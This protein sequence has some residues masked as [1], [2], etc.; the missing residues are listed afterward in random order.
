MNFSQT[1]FISVNGLFDFDLTF[2]TEA[3]LF[4][5]LAIVV[6]FA[7]L[8]PISKQ[9]DERAEFLNYTIKKSAILLTFGFEKLQNCVGLLTSEIDELN[10]EIKLVK[11]YTNTKFE[12]EAIKVQKETSKIVSQLKGD[13]SIKSAY[14]IAS[15]GSDLDST[16]TKFFDK[17]F[18]SI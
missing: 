15:L 7:F 17:K 9:L 1:F 16:T 5:I 18:K 4:L 10:R 8:S 14:V 11:N 12:N 2:P 13:L 3:L 6:T